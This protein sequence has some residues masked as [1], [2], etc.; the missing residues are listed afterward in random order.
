MER[1]PINMKKA[2]LIHYDGYF[3]IRLKYVEQS[4]Q[5]RGFKVTL[6]FSDFDHYTKS[7]KKYPNSNVHKIHVPVTR[8]IFISRE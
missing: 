1:T 6:I 4:L 3:D 7:S 5:E 2:F 8:K